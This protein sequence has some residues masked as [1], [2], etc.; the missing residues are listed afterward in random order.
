MS[1]SDGLAALVRERELDAQLV[2]DAVDVRYLTGYT[3]SN[4]AAL[5]GPDLRRFATDFRYAE[6]VATEVD[7]TWDVTIANEDLVRGL[8]GGLAL[9]R[10][11]FDP[12]QLTVEEHAKLAEY[13]GEG[14][15]L[16]PAK[17]LVGGLRAVKDDAEIARIASAAELADD[18]LAWVVSRGLAGRTERDVVVALEHELRLRGAEPSFDTIVAAGEHGARPHAVPRDVEIPAGTLVVV[19]LGA[20]LDGY[21][22]DCTRT[23][24]V[25]PVGDEERAVYALV[26][27]AQQAALDGLRAGLSGVEVDALARD[28]I[29]AAGHGDRFGH[30]LGHGVGLEVHE[31]PR[32]S[33]RAPDDPLLAGNVVTVEPGVYL[34][35]RFGVRIEDLVVVE[36]DGVRNLSGFTKDLL[37]VG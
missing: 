15:E 34:P 30:G 1:R 18:I 23:F 9:E 27:E 32:L 36:D 20:Q 25:G 35:G 6:S 16:V 31:P 26:A 17:G 12:A 28:R 3:G 4:G 11:G 21:C 14:V 29:E 13:L 37:E 2:A 7:D 19:D 22:S 24:A 33:R 8:L 10:V 5:V